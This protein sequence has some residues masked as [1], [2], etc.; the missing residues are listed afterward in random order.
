MIEIVP[1]W[2]PI[3]VH[4]PLALLSVSVIF[5][6]LARLVRRHRWQP[7]WLAVAHWN[8]WIGAGFAVITGVTGWL[9]YNSVAHDDVS[10]AAMTVHRNW[11]IPTILLFGILAAWA[12]WSHRRSREVGAI[13]LASAVVGL[14]LLASTGWRGGELVYRHGLGVM[15]L[16]ASVGDGH[17]HE[18]N[19]AP[20]Q[21][22]PGTAAVPL[23]ESAP[24]QQKPGGGADSKEVHVHKDGRVHEH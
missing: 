17:D 8:L 2:H 9:A 4:F 22:A 19:A 15:S 3:F 16:P 7:Q 23:G 24:T 1:N 18:Y 5:F 10:H 20:I 14:G 11:A 12:A 6:L 13:F 21:A